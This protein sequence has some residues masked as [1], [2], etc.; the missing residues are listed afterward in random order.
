MDAR[1]SLKYMIRY[2]S[3]TLEKMASMLNYSTA[4]GLNN[5]INNKNGIRLK[6]F[7]QCADLLEFDVVL[8]DRYGDVEIILDAE[9]DDKGKE[10]YGYVKPIG[11]ANL[12]D[13]G[14]RTKSEA[15]LDT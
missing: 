2:R 14:C 9:H 12:G 4:S 5:R 6:L 10:N 1:K 8:K 11:K 13:T 7:L 3:A 15:V